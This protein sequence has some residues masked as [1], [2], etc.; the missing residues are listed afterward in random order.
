M[1]AWIS[2]Q[3]KTDDGDYEKILSELDDKV[4]KAEVKLSEIKIRERR[5]NVM[6]MLYGL[7][8]WAIYLAYC[9]ATLHNADVE[10]ETFALKVAPVLLIPVIIYLGRRGL[11]WFYNR[12]QANEESNL[13]SLR[14][15]QK[16]KVEELKKKTSYYTTKSLLERYDQTSSP[17]AKPAPPSSHPG[18]SNK[19]RE[20]N[21]Q[22]PQGLQASQGRSSQMAPNYPVPNRAANPNMQPNS[23]SKAQPLQL[24]QPMPQLQLRPSVPTERQWYD[25]LV[26]ALVGEDGPET[27]YALIC[28]HCST[29]NGLV[30]PQEIETIQYIC[31]KCGQFNPSR[32][33]RQ[34]HPGGPVLPPGVSPANSRSSSP[35]VARSLSRGAEVHRPTSQARDRSVDSDHRGRSTSSRRV[36]ASRDDTLD[37]NEEQ[38]DTDQVE[39]EKHSLKSSSPTS[40][41]EPDTIASRVRQRKKAVSVEEDE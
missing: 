38:E 40:G 12:K 21:P 3:K 30:L 9:F 15:K 19:G 24:G 1:G 6:F 11:K 5:I 31:P 8:L 17:K 22:F 4:Q 33:S 34:L 26:D 13:S 29:H 25:K 36:M 28:N 18:S 20:R 16:L 41:E 14:S 2:R 39:F 10:F 35:N 7:A 27:K 32:R 23:L 37:E